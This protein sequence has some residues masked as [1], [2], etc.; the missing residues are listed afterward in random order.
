VAVASEGGDNPHFGLG[1]EA[2]L[3]GRAPALMAAGATLEPI[4]RRRGDTWIADVSARCPCRARRRQV[5]QLHPPPLEPSTTF[6]SW[7]LSPVLTYHSQRVSSG[8][9]TQ[10]SVLVA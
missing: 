2:K 8:P 3:A 7:S 4:T 5:E 9:L 10:V 1:H 6:C